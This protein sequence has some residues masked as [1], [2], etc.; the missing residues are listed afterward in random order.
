[1]KQGLVPVLLGG[2][3][4]LGLSGCGLKT[5][6]VPPGAVIPMAIDDLTYRLDEKGVKL[7]WTYPPLSVQGAAID[8]IREFKIFKA[9]KNEA[10]FC[11]ECSVNYALVFAVNAS[12]LKPGRE[13]EFSDSGLKGNY[14]YFYM[15]Q[16]HSGWNIH[17]HDSNLAG[18]VW[19]SPL[20]APDNLLAQAGDRLVTLSWNRPA[21][22]AD[23]G[24]VPE[25]IG[26]LVSRS[27]DGRKFRNLTQV[28]EHNS[29]TDGSVKNGVD[30]FY[31]VKAL[32]KDGETT[33][34]GLSS[35]VVMVHPVDATPP[36]PPRQV[37][38]VRAAH[39]VKVFWE[40]SGETD[41]SAH[42]VYRRLADETRL[43]LIGETGGADHLFVDKNP[44]EEA[45]LWYYSVSAVDD[46]ENANESSR[47]L[48][49][50]MTRRR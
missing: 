13:V 21:G 35:A 43:E 2:F 45:A 15:V 17:S 5:D 4:L 32:Y 25:A 42:R 26:Y 12:S 39:Q 28:I 46:A 30:Y 9:E 1:M 20:A 50:E 18:F 10:D 31:R 36:A 6:P 3:V 44:P 38:C 40:N 47:S 29:F 34:P 24:P 16:S 48:E 41:I 14:H 49:A 19:H 22:L 11:P 8:N 23:G 33:Y 37:R 7:T 27:E